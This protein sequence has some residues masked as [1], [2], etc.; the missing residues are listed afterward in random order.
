[1]LLVYPAKKSYVSAGMDVLLKGT[2]Q[3]GGSSVPR[4]ESNTFPTIALSETEENIITVSPFK[5]MVGGRM[6]VSTQEQY[7]YLGYVDDIIVSLLVDL[8][9]EN[10]THGSIESGSYDY[11]LN[12]PE[13][14]SHDYTFVGFHATDFRYNSTSPVLEVPL[15]RA[16]FVKKTPESGT[17][18]TREL[19][20]TQSV[21]C[22]PSDLGMF[23]TVY[24]VGS[25]VVV[26]PAFDWALFGGTW[27]ELTDFGSFYDAADDTFELGE[28]DTYSSSNKIY[29]REG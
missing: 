27:R 15:F 29:V 19:E 13:F 1:M 22:G 8:R 21:F 9:E 2:M 6:V 24:P 23:D 4:I 25:I 17:T 5:M 28:N 20:V 3:G 10:V 14:I 11:D 18:A 7:F 26:G 12:Q 16:R